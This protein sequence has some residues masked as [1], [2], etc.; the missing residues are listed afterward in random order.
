MEITISILSGYFA[1]LP[2]AHSASR[3]CSRRS[4]GIYLGWHTLELTSAPT[5]LQGIAV[6]EIIFFVLN[7]LLFA[8]VGLPP[9]ILDA[10]AGRDV[11]DLPRTRCS[12][13]PS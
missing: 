3:A 6:W 2:A 11:E 9:V 4:A 10:L 1:F 8:L 7:G 5:R 13:R 12:S